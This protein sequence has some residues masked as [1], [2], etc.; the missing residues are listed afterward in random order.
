MVAKADTMYVHGGPY[1]AEEELRD[2][3]ESVVADDAILE[4]V[5]RIEEDGT[6][7]WAPS[8]QHRNKIDALETAL[9]EQFDQ[10]E[11]GFE[12]IEVLA[13]ERES[14]NVGSGQE[15]VTRGELLEHIAALKEALSKPAT[16]G[17]I[18][19]N[20]PPAEFELEV[21][22]Q[23]EVAESLEVI[24][25]ELTSDQPDV[26]VVAKKSSALSRIIGWIGGKLNTTAEAFCKSFGSTLG[27]TAGLALPAVIVASPY[28][29]KLVALLGGLKEWL[30]L[31]LG[32]L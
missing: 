8:S 6:F 31:A 24:E 19:H 16:H 2:N 29:G 14:V 13:S 1:N 5:S 23:A 12:E 22:Q 4:A 28:W 32:L 18:G 27:K 21:E 26:E 30:M 3:F 10:A 17:G 25:A 9:A 11:Y 15:L 7:D 20:Q